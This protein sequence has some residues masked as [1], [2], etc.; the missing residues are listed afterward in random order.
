MGF[1]TRSINDI[2]F[3]WERC[4][5]F[6]DESQSLSRTMRYSVLQSSPGAGVR[7]F[8]LEVDRGIL[9]V[10]TIALLEQERGES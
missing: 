7:T 6:A 8:R 3:L 4:I 9:P 2:E 5:A 1:K 10:D